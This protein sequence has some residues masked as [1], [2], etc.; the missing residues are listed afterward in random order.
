MNKVI[1]SKRRIV[2]L[3]VVFCLLFTCMLGTSVEAAVLDESQ[4]TWQTVGDGVAI[5][6]YLGNE[7]LVVIPAQLGGQNVVSVGIEGSYGAFG[8]HPEITELVLPEGLKRICDEV[9]WGCSGMSKIWLPKSLE[10]I[11]V[12][13]FHGCTSITD[14]YFAGS[15]EEW[16]NVNISSDLYGNSE[17]KNALIHFQAAYTSQ[18]EAVNDASQAAQTSQSEAVNDDSQRLFNHIYES[19]GIDSGQEAS[20]PGVESAPAEG[21]LDPTGTFTNDQVMSLRRFLRIPDDLAAD[22]VVDL[23]D[24]K[25]WDGAGLTV[26]WVEFRSGDET[27]ASCYA[28][29]ST[30]QAATEIMAYSGQAAAQTPEPTQT[31]ESV[32]AAEPVPVGQDL[33]GYLNGTSGQ[34]YDSFTIGTDSLSNGTLTLITADEAVEFYFIY[35][36]VYSG[37]EQVVYQITLTE[38][39]KGLYRFGDLTMNDTMSQMEEK[40]AAKGFRKFDEITVESSCLSKYM[41][42]N[43]DIVYTIHTDLNGNVV[44]LIVRNPVSKDIEQYNS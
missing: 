37:R 3:A 1:S 30:K 40:L 17:I 23:L 41:S 13:A 31:P 11:G 28:D 6:S 38:F 9:F 24:V 29:M 35:D 25:N 18:S 4:C 19:L 20:V 14:V 7:S 12:R 27:I 21:M 2:I 26:V 36:A 42:D 34:V 32:Q 16:Q 10:S 43:Q 44:G 22:C 15:Q 39:S 8:E 5:T 33:L